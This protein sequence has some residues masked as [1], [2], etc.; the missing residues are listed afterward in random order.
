ME[1]GGGGE[2]DEAG[3]EEEG[4]RGVQPGRTGGS[5]A[6]PQLFQDKIR[7]KWIHLKIPCLVFS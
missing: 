7:P 5:A 4:G 6:V 3:A 1:F 2:A